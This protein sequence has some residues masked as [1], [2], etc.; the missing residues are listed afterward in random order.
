MMQDN[1]ERQQPAT[2]LFT[3]YGD[4]WIRGSEQCLLDLITH[5]DKKKFN[6]ILWCNHKIMESEAKALGI[7]V[8]RSGF[9]L[10]LGWHQPRFDL[11]AFVD[12]VQHAVQLIDKHN[13]TLMHANGIDTT[14]LQQQETVDLHHLLKIGQD[15]FIIMT[16]GFLIHRK[17]TD[18]IIAT[19]LFLLAQGNPVQLVIAGEA[20]RCIT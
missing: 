6:A 8:T 17:G 13:I 18:V 5:L 7:Q 9:L 10:L 3:Y 15:G 16:V 20:L 12:L 11:A 1:S 2:T 19:M 14:R 4:N